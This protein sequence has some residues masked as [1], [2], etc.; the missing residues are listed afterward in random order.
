MSSDRSQS[1]IQPLNKRACRSHADLRCGV[2]LVQPGVGLMQQGVVGRL[3]IRQLQH[4]QIGRPSGSAGA[5]RCSN[6]LAC[7]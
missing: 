7:L 3:C 6:H 2:A 4:G 1:M 5:G